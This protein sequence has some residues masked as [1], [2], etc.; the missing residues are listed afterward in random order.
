MADQK[1]VEKI[2]IDSK[3][4]TPDQ[5]A[6]AQKTLAANPEGH[7]LHALLFH[8]FINKDQMKTI[9][10]LYDTSVTKK[11]TKTSIAGEGMPAPVARKTTTQMMA[12]IPSG[13]M[14]TQKRVKPEAP[15]G[16]MVMVAAPV[17]APTIPPIPASPLP[18][19][20]M[21]KYF[22]AARDMGASDLHINTGS[23]PMIRKEGKLTALNRPPLSAKEALELVT[24]VL[25]PSQRQVLAEQKFVEF[26]Y[27][28]PGMGRYRSCVLKQRL[29]YNGAFRIVPLRPFTFKELALPD[30]IRK[31]TEYHQGLVLAT[32]PKGC[33]KSTTL[34][35]L[36]E[37]INQDR[38]EHI[39]TIEDPIEYVFKPALSHISQRE[40][41]SH[42][43]T[44]GAA[45]RAALREDPDVVMIGELR[46]FGT[47]SLAIT[48]AETGHLVFSTLHTTSSISTIERV[49]DVFPANQQN[50]IRSMI[51]ESLKGILC[52][53]LV[54]RKDGKGR[55]LA[56]E[57]L[58]NTMAASN[59]IREQQLQQLDSVMQMGKKLGMATMDNTLLELTEKNIIDGY[60]AHMLANNKEKFKNWQPG[61]K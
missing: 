42:T 2:V 38:E 4:V 19:D 17:A 20:V 41:I 15:A 12:Q 43:K 57:I 47:T 52:Q 55:V 58:F 9:V 22:K 27:A 21:H 16:N 46:D 8:K 14:D 30:Q 11:R 37:L 29:G 53:Q 51:S 6:E 48:A 18:P 10:Q 45:L 34:A 1:F 50:Q 33:G 5:L 56:M 44:F 7:L 25:N 49:L 28:P 31:L 54:P 61:V 39:I 59:L 24:C 36:V 35:A 26:C 32:G 60:Q 3:L 40:V 13:G 23:P